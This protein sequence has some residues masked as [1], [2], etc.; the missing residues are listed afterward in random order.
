[1]D[2]KKRR[3]FLWIGF[4]V[5]AI[6]VIAVAESIIDDY[7]NI[8]TAFPNNPQRVMNEFGFSL[9]IGMCII[10]PFLGAEL[11]FIRS[12]YKMLKHNPKGC[13]KICYMIS[14]CLAFLAFAFQC[15]ISIGL[16]DF[17]EERGQNFAADILLFTEWP[18]FIVSFVL[19]S[20]PIKH[21]D[22]RNA[23][24]QSF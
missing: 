8:K 22:C 10:F 20:I 23:S 11:S 7:Y 24:T 18:T 17:A 21:H 19:G 3:L 14:S 15:L 4:A 16:I 13:V 6:S 5:F 9:F 12:V 2:N 1:M